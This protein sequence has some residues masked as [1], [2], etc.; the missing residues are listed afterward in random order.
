MIDFPIYV[1]DFFQYPYILRKNWLVYEKIYSVKTASHYTANKFLIDFFGFCRS[2]V[3]T[4]QGEIREKILK[5]IT[6]ELASLVPLRL[7]PSASAEKH[8]NVF[9]K[10]RERD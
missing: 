6:V 7:K 4:L 10:G 2:Q 3:W 5:F 8:E 1:T 9:T